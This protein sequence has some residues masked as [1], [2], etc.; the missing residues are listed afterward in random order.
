MRP[1][2]AGRLVTRGGGAI[3]LKRFHDGAIELMK[4]ERRVD[5]F[6]RPALDA[7]PREPLAAV[8]QA[9]INLRRRNEGLRIAEEKL[10]PGEEAFLDSIIADM[11]AYMRQHYVSGEFQRAGNTKTHGI[12][13]GEFTELRTFRAWVRFAGPGPASPPY[14]E[15]SRLRQSMNATPHREPT[16]DEVFEPVA[17]GQAPK[18]VR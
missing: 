8:V 3:L 18:L 4:L 15:L 10:L 12:V 5:P 11:A 2:R 7:L 17:D 16:G 6:F 13:R 9:L 1:A 14:W